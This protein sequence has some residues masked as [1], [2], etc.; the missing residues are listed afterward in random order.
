[1]KRTD[2]I[3]EIEH[4]QA[5]LTALDAQHRLNGHLYTPAEIV[6]VRKPLALLKQLV[7]VGLY[8][9]KCEKEQV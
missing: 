7:E 6:N 1:M 8:D 2:Y 9:L 3:R 4:F 5:V